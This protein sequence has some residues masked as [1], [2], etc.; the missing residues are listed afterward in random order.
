MGVVGLQRGGVRADGACEEAPVEC[1]TPA[2]TPAEG[3]PRT[4]RERDDMHTPT[5]RRLRGA[6][7]LLAG[8]LAL[9]ACGGTDPADRPASASSPSTM[10]AAPSSPAPAVP[11]RVEPATVA[12]ASFSGP[13]VDQF[14]AEPVRTAY[15][16]VAE[17][18]DQATFNE[19]AMP[20]DPEPTAEAFEG[21][22]AYM[23][24]SM[25]ADFRETVR[26]AVADHQAAMDD[27]NSM[28]FNHMEGDGLEFGDG[29]WVTDHTIGDPQAEVSPD[30]N[31][32]L[33]VVEKATV[34]ID[35]GG[36]PV[37]VPITKTST[38]FLVPTTDG[39]RPWLIN[40]ITGQWETGSITPDTSTN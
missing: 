10:T 4:H 18:L 16:E 34:H 14:G 36:S 28:V 38:F 20:S 26:E 30:G 6:A 8:A 3:V 31:L 9:A 25:A 22:T 37:L 7:G 29:Q 2:R 12:P 17:Y 40:G 27:L 24:P 39:N 21:L 32:K 19:D 13:A 5:V 23:T 11:S 15:A 35:Q 33:V 1:G